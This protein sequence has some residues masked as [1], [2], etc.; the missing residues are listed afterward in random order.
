MSEREASSP[1]VGITVRKRGPYIVRGGVPISRCR[2]VVSEHG[3]PAGWQTTER[4]DTQA[5]VTLCRCGQS[6]N[7]PFCDATHRTESF[8]GRETAPTTTYDERAKSYQRDHLTVRDDRGICVHAGFC[9]NAST[10]VWKM[11]GP[12][13]DD[14]DL[15]AEMTGMIERCPSGALTFRLAGTEAD[16]EPVLPQAIA[17]VDDG[18]LF[19]TGGVPI[20]RADERPF[21]TRNRVTLCR[22]GRSA[23]KPLCDGSHREA[24]FRDSSAALSRRPEL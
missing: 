17:V 20:S 14:A 23:T 9:S 21:E 22:C 4:F 15:R 1:P 7:K 19:V 13:D 8:E 3:E 24:G 18:P 12:A 10:N 2:P 16:V 11:V 5:V 6:R